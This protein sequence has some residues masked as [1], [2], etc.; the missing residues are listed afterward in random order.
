[1]P[2]ECSYE[3]NY[4]QEPALILMSYALSR[5]ATHNSANLVLFL[6]YSKK[7]NKGLLFTSIILLMREYS[8]A[9]LPVKFVF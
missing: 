8:A 1:M 6:C 5:G 3:A 2:S 9:W 7:E 4:S